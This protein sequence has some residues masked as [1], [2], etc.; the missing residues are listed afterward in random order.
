MTRQVISFAQRLFLLGIEGYDKEARNSSTKGVLNPGGAKV[1]S[2]PLRGNN[3]RLVINHKGLLKGLLSFNLV[4]Y[5]LN[6]IE[7]KDGEPVHVEQRNGETGY[8]RVDTGLLLYNTVG[9]AEGGRNLRD[10][11][12]ESCKPE[13]VTDYIEV[14]SKIEDPDGKIKEAAQQILYRDFAGN[15]VPIKTESA[16]ILAVPSGAEGTQAMWALN[17]SSIAV[18]VTSTA[19]RRTGKTEDGELPF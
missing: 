6:R 16:V 15:M 7:M 1:F 8:N 19:N 18:S 9:T 4:V 10:R 13:D 11:L 17:S 12:I 3:S 2:Q 5:T 14:L